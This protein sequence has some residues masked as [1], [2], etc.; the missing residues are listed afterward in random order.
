[1]KK[2]LLLLLLPIAIH[3]CRKDKVVVN[4]NS[5]IQNTMASDYLQLKVGN[6]WIYE[7][8]QFN[9]TSID[10]TTV[11]RDSI[12]RNNKYAVL[13]GHDFRR[14]WVILNILRD[15]SNYII[16][17][18]GEIQFALDNFVDTLHERY[19]RD[20]SN[21]LFASISYKMFKTATPINV[22]AGEFDNTLNYRGE[23]FY[24]DNRNKKYNQYYYSKKIG[25]IQTI[26]PY[27]NGTDKFE[28]KLIRYNVE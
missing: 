21:N 13:E 18:N 24:H 4:N 20:G 6:Y 15:S 25:L 17:H 22:P 2:Y 14:D 8:S 16:N 3:S 10:S 12:I 11:T 26:E 1:M 7:V 9:S 28:K 23:I 5:N 27:S 19:I